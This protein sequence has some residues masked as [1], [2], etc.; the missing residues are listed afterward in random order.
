VSRRRRRRSRS[1]RVVRLIVPA[2]VGVA[3]YFALFGGEFSAFD[4][5]RARAEIGQAQA[6]LD[7][8]RA[9]TDS[10][11]LR[12]DSLENDP[13]AIERVARE[14]YGFIRDGEILYKFEEDGPNQPTSDRASAPDTGRR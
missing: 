1:G 11:R 4:V 8:L 3:G 10:L 6:Q 7:G 13:A 9:E 5:R 12:A 2:V 14:Q